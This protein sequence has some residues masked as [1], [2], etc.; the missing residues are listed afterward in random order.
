MRT[1]KK[2]KGWTRKT[3]DEIYN[4]VDKEKREN[5]RKVLLAH[6]L[7]DVVRRLEQAKNLGVWYEITQE[8]AKA[9][10]N[11]VVEQ[12]ARAAERELERIVKINR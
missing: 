3:Y 12:A 9:V 4:W 2:V 10:G 8:A 5:V 7:D 11:K 1:E 6:G